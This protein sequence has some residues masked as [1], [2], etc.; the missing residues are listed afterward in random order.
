MQTQ[1]SRIGNLAIALFLMILP[2]PHLAEAQ[3]QRKLPRIGYLSDLSPASS[4]SPAFMQGLRDL[5]YVE[6]KN[7]DFVFR[8]PER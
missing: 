2:R 5:G 6:G 7:I 1:K 8:T 3:Q 4:L